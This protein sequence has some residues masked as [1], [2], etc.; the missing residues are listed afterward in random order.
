VNEQA[1]ETI[2][3]IDRLT[4]TMQFQMFIGKT[5]FC[6]YTLFWASSVYCPTSQSISWRL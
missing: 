3:P 5:K 1:N 4:N 6:H 2:Q